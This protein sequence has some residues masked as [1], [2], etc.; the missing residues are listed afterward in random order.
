MLGGQNRLALLAEGPHTI[1][2][3][4]GWLLRSQRDGDAGRLHCFNPAEIGKS[5]TFGAG[6]RRVRLVDHETRRDSFGVLLER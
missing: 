5:N 1:R 3:P 4:I 2:P 6:R